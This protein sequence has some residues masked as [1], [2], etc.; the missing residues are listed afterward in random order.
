MLVALI[1][2]IHKLPLPQNFMRSNIS[3][4][5]NGLDS[6]HS[7]TIFQRTWYSFLHSISLLHCSSSIFFHFSDNKCSLTI[8]EP[9]SRHN[10]MMAMTKWRLPEKTDNMNMKIRFFSRMQ[11]QPWKKPP[12][13]DMID[14]GRSNRMCLPDTWY[15]AG[16]IDEIIRSEAIIISRLSHTNW[17]L[18]LTHMI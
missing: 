10:T 4:Y 17:V 5:W 6:E 13:I 2:P 9:N 12:P 8:S 18:T 7:K 3:N 16:L 11:S 14:S 1:P 15:S